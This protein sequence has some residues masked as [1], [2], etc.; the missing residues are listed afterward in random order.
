MRPVLRPGLQILRRDLRTLQLG[1]DWPGLAVVQDSRA[2][3]AVLGAVDGFRDVDGVLLAAAAQPDLRR[4]ECSAALAMLIEAGAIVDRTLAEPRQ[5]D[6]ATFASWWL[7]A[8]PDS[9]A[10]SI[11]GQRQSCRVWVEGGQHRESGSAIATRA[12]K[13]IALAG[14]TS[15]DSLATADIVIAAVD[16]IPDRA[17]SDELMHDAVP[18]VWVYLRDLVGV[19][20]PLVV[21]GQ[22][23]CLRC[24]DAAR[25]E[26]DPTWP[27]VLSSA[28]ARPRSVNPCDPVVATLVAAWAVQE[29]AIWASG[30]VPSSYD[31]VIDVPLGLAPATSRSYG[32]HPH[33]G[34]GWQT[35]Q[36]TMG[37]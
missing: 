19:I 30:L 34:C 9:G 6:Q 5:A 3:Q 12:R 17:Q 15:A 33:C 8:G 20:G 25:T 24:T 31:S 27:A 26:L 14:L 32:I 22:S 23:A 29:V 18:H 4:D 13:L 28:I 7:L 35:W 36:D 1:H 37:A 21:P 2:L 10:D 16:G 11:A